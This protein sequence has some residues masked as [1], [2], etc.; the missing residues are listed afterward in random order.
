MPIHPNTYSH[1]RLNP[2]HVYKGIIALSELCFTHV[3]WTTHPRP[4]R[5]QPRV[6]PQ[7]CKIAKQWRPSPWTPH[8][9]LPAHQSSNTYKQQCREHVGKVEP[10]PR[11][12]DDHDAIYGLLAQGEVGVSE[13]RIGVKEGSGRCEIHKGT[14]EIVEQPSCRKKS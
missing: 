8:L 1:R 9:P 14:H 10:I 4:H 5:R 13:S 11:T 6:L 12:S 3:R 7:L 2:C